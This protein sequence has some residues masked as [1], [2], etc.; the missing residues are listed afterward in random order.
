MAGCTEDTVAYPPPLQHRSN[1]PPQ[2]QG[3]V[4]APKAGGSKLPFSRQVDLRG[5][6]LSMRHVSGAKT[7]CGC[8][9]RAAHAVHAILGAL[10]ERGLEAVQQHCSRMPTGETC[11]V[12]LQEQA[13]AGCRNSSATP[14]M[15]NSPAA[16]LGT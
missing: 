3:E 9:S 5:P 2:Q 7:V 10:I 13:V 6:C 4:S 1:S 14:R 16:H 11:R 8:A 12:A 15:I